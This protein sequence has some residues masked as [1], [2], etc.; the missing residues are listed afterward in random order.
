M[1]TTTT[2]KN[3][4]IRKAFDCCQNEISL[5]ILCLNCGNLIEN[6]CLENDDFIFNI[7]LNSI[8]RTM[9]IKDDVVT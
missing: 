8:N 6:S 3:Y 9:K 5:L 4:D 2:N 1:T 7:F